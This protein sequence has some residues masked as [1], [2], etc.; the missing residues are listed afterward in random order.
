MKNNFIYEKRNDKY[1]WQNRNTKF[2]I[3]DVSYQAKDEYKFQTSIS[4]ILYL[5]YSID[6]YAKKDKQWKTICKTGAY[7]FPA[8]IDFMLNL[9]SILNLDNETEG[10]YR[11]QGFAYEDYYD[12]E[13]TIS[14]DGRESFKLFIGANMD[15]QPDFS[16]SGVMINRLTRYDLT[17]L[18]KM[19]NAIFSDCIRNNNKKIK[20]EL[21]QDRKY[22]I[23][24]DRLLYYSR[25]VLRNI[26]KVGDCIDCTVLK[27]SLA[28]DNYSSIRYH[29]VIISKLVS[30]NENGDYMETMCGYIELNNDPTVDMSHVQIK[31][32]D[33][34]NTFLNVE[35]EVLSYSEDD[36]I[37]D[38]RNYLIEAEIQQIK[39]GDLD[40]LVK[41]WCDCVINRYWLCRSEHN[42]PKRVNKD[43]T[44]A[45]IRNAELSVRFI[46]SQ[47][48]EDTSA[49]ADKVED[50][51][52]VDD[53]KNVEDAILVN[54]DK[55]VEDKPYEV[56]FLKLN[57][58]F[59]RKKER[60]S[61]ETLEEDDGTV[62]VKENAT[63]GQVVE[64]E[65]VYLK[66][67]KK[68]ESISD[69]IS[70]LNEDE[71]EGLVNPEVWGNVRFK[72]ILNMRYRMPEY[73]VGEVVN[74]NTWIGFKYGF[75]I[76]DI[77][78]IFHERLAELT[79]GYKVYKENEK[80]GFSF[81]YVPE[82]YLRKLN[83]EVE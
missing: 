50:V 49:N 10:S 28:A 29:N 38:L 73:T 67:E 71:L 45:H 56:D 31:L 15:T 14:S 39:D 83:E 8:L 20:E 81:D 37:K 80:T 42:L 62:K 11:T 69:I 65:A 68:E 52:S 5:Y 47:I 57:G 82:G 55:N 61:I 32:S 35:N 64:G 48:K 1:V 44:D 58:L 16:C 36:I 7:D 72:D 22:I 3:S 54:D 60:T 53:G 27:G 25:G 30:D 74:M 66:E 2:V 9:E 40:D 79:Y 23:S 41:E 63:V 70:K 75:K 12:I 6:V 51:T 34:V 76:I 24:N 26:Y 78:A 59:E 21:S 4:D 33:I 13:K 43:V 18:M 17:V 19:L 77:M 46:L